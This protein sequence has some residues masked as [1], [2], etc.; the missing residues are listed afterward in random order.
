MKIV[1]LSRQIGSFGDEIATILAEKAGLKVVNQ[2]E[3]H[4]LAEAC[5]PS[6]KKACSLYEREVPKNFLERFFF[7]DPAYVSLFEALNFELASQGNVI[8]IGRGAQIAL[9]GIPGIFKVR[10]VASSEARAL[11][12]MEQQNI[13]LDLAK[14]IVHSHGHRRRA[15]VEGIYHHDLSDWALYD[16]IIN[17]EKMTLEEAADVALGAF[18][19]LRP[20][21]DPQKLSRELLAKSVAKKVESAIRHEV[22]PAPFSSLT[23]CAGEPGEVI[24]SGAVIENGSKKRAEKIASGFEGVTKVVNHIAASAAFSAY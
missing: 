21:D 13:P 8:L 9:Q 4:K 3:I 20:V 22:S 16:V 7:D 5:D 17:T 23:V 24:L 6:F 18:N 15:M 12:V 10:V 11:R 14:D 1:S 2:A 19:G